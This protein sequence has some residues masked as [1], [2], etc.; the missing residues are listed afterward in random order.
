MQ[1]YNLCVPRVTK[2]YNF[3]DTE[4]NLTRYINILG[5]KICRIVRLYRLH[6]NL[7][8]FYV[9]NRNVFIS[10]YETRQ[11][12]ETRFST[13]NWTDLYPTPQ[14]CNPVIDFH[15]G[16][17][18]LKFYPYKLKLLNGNSFFH[19]SNNNLT[20]HNTLNYI[21]LFINFDYPKLFQNK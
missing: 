20:D 7:H 8:L 11:F 13:F 16:F 18:F 10:K 19:F 6:D 1:Q 2:F 14:K 21:K 12:N 3:E 5:I 4:W 15:S 17:L 9:V